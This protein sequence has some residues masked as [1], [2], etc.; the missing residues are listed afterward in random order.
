MPKLPQTI[1][2]KLVKQ[3]PR[4]I[5]WLPG[6]GK[7]TC[8]A[9]YPNIYVPHHVYASLRSANP[10]PKYI[11]VLLHEQEHLHRMKQHGVLVWNLRYIFIRRFRFNEELAAVKPQKDYLQQQGQAYD[12]EA[13][14]KMLSGWLYL[15]STS[16]NKA[17]ERLRD[18]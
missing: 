11:A 13:K 1:D 6:I 12:D 3:K 7:A 16:Y 9:V 2:L 10:E 17:L 4:L 5:E 15:W 18:L 8:Q 14:A